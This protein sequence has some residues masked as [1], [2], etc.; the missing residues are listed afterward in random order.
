M[1]SEHDQEHL[2]IN[3]VKERQKCELFLLFNG[4]GMWYTLEQGLCMVSTEIQISTSSVGFYTMKKAE[5]EISLLLFF[6]VFN[7]FFL[8]S[9]AFS[10]HPQNL[11]IFN[12]L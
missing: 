2:A 6:Q 11:S 1:V 3:E 7:I 8:L 12:L 4:Q 5:E 10:G 9:S